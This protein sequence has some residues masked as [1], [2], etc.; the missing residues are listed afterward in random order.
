MDLP[1]AVY[2]AGDSPQWG[3]G[4]AFYDHTTTGPT[5]ARGYLVTA[6]QFAD[7]LAQELH[8]IP[9]PGDPIEEL[10][11]AGVDGRH[12]LGRGRYETLLEVGHYDD[13]P[14]LTFTA[15]HGIDGVEHTSPSAAYLATL[16][17]GL[18]EA[19][20]WDVERIAGYFAGLG[21]THVPPRVAGAAEAH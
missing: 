17:V 9:E 6:A 14:M 7:I 5:A 16:R 21:V 15:P 11:V 4:V 1:G 20:G 12:Q 2:F 18:R 10:V 3:G 8:R 19:R 13:R